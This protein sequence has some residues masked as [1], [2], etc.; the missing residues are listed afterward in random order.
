[1]S[2]FHSL[3]P[4][5]L[6]ADL[7]KTIEFYTELLDFELDGSWPRE[8]PTWIQLRRGDLR[9]MFYAKD[10]KTEGVPGMTGVLYFTIDDVPALHRRLE[11]KVQIQWG[12]EVYH[13]GMLE[14]AIHDCNG[15]TLSFGQP[16]DEAPTCIDD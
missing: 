2:D 11:G 4:M 15:Y 6:S 8:A 9:V 14:F 5:L 7:A 16:S 13:Y 10:E 3:T 12:P 1:M